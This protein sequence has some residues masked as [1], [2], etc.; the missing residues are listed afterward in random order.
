MTTRGGRSSDRAAPRRARRSRACAICAA[1]VVVSFAVLGLVQPVAAQG[2][3]DPAPAVDGR[4]LVEQIGAVGR[5]GFLY[6][7]TRPAAD[8]SPDQ[9]LFL[10]GT[11]HVGRVGGEPFNPTLVRAL[12]QSRRLAL[13]ADPT[14]IDTTQRLVQRLGEYEPPDDLTH[15]VPP[16]LMT[17][18]N[19]F[20][21]QSGLPAERVD[22][23]K[24]WLLATVATVRKISG[25]G[26]DPSLG[27]ELYLAGFA[28]AAGMKIVEVEGVEAQLTFLAS[29][30]DAM[31]LAELDEALADTD[32]DDRYDG[33]AMFALWLVGDAAGAD[34]IV[35]DLH[36][37]A[38]DKTFARWFVD[39][40]IDG[41]NRTMADAVERAL[42]ESGT[43]FFAVGA[44]HLFGESG[45]VRELRRRGYRVTDLQAAP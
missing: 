1:A 45:L 13:E 25:T 10:Y 33:Q 20:A 8:A 2:S 36:A 35:A 15:H 40:L 29:L 23:M 26:L 43:T 24:P 34:R 11:I 12:R 7:V 42:A 14:D 32:D 44:L 18:V 21:A 4:R 17:R 19:A 6:E 41:R 38:A 28:H 3:S 22:R 27:S 16:A 31:Q 5:R 37:E 39:T 30:P 9:R